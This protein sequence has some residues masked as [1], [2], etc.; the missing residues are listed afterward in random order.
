MDARSRGSVALTAASGGSGKT[1]A[2]AAASSHA[3][4]EAADG[5]TD[6][7]GGAGDEEER[8]MNEALLEILQRPEVIR[9]LRREL[10]AW[11]RGQRIADDERDAYHEPE[12]DYRSGVHRFASWITTAAWFDQLIMFTIFLNA[13]AIAVES[14]QAQGKDADALQLVDLLFLTVYIVEFFLKVYVEPIGYW[15]SGYNRFDFVILALSLLQFVQIDGLDLTYVRVLR[16]LRALRALR[17]VS[18]IRQLRVLVLALLKTL[19]SISNLLIL[20]LLIMYVFAIM[21]FYLFGP[22]E[23]TKGARL[24]EGES[25]WATVFGA[26]YSLWVMTTADGWTDIQRRLD[27]RGFG[28]SRIF[29]VV[30]LFIGHFIFTNLFIGIIIQN[31]DEAQSNERLYQRARQSALVKAKKGIIS[32]SQAADIRQLNSAYRVPRRRRNARRQ[33]EHLDLALAEARRDAR[34]EDMVP[35]TDIAFN[36]TWLKAF[37][38][39]LEWQETI[40]AR[41]HSLHFSLAGTLAEMAAA[42][43][44]ARAQLGDWWTATRGQA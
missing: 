19:G 18:F 26:M 40:S 32:R 5:A 28:T 30:Y 2:A 11:K 16:A 13:V 8:R 14:S 29:T 21:G 38:A 4:P 25:E 37:M 42:D 44:G 3:G 22:G 23:E 36:V 43:G 31:L 35:L 33:A 6:G 39:T 24:T 41:C 17:S 12:R 20:L 7:R 15:R 27:E 10:D 9:D 34:K 1:D